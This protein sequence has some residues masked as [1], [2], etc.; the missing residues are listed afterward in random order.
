MYFPSNGSKVNEWR[1]VD[2]GYN[3]RSLIIIPY[4]IRK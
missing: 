1:G 3:T 4:R 2:V